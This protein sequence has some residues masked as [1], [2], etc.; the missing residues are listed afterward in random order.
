MKNILSILFFASLLSSCGNSAQN[1]AISDEKK[2]LTVLEQ[3]Q[4]GAIPTASAGWVM[5]AKID[6]KD[7][8]ATSIMP[9][10]AAAS[11]VGKNNN[12]IGVGLP[13]Y[14][15]FMVLGNKTKFSHSE[16]VDIFTDENVPGIWKGFS[17]EMEIT[18][19]DGDWVEGK[20]IVTGTCDSYPDKKMEIT[21]GFFRILLA[22]KK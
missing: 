4:P 22:S 6:G 21:D 7:W 18:K 17:G 12:G 2:A 8:S 16:P 3:L 5:T 10:D 13:Y 11:I 20:F 9:P 19:I 14:R 15:R 1:K